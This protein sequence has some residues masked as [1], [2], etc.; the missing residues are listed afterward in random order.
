MNKI[1][2]LLLTCCVVTFGLMSSDAHASKSNHRHSS[3]DCKKKKKFL[4]CQ[5]QDIS[6]MWISSETIL[7]TY[8]VVSNKFEIIGKMG[9]IMFDIAISPDGVLYGL[10]S[11]GN[12]LYKINTKNAS[13]TLVGT[14]NPS[15][16]SNSL[17]F[18]PDGV[19]YAIQGTNLITIDPS[20]ASVNILGDTG[21]ASAGDITFYENN[22]FMASTTNQLILIDISNP[23]NS[24]AIANIPETFGLATLFIGTKGCCTGNFHLYGTSGSDLSV[25]EIDPFTGNISNSVT[26]PSF[27]PGTSFTFGAT[28]QQ[29]NCLCCR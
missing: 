26:L 21:F 18:G 29:F 14:L 2:R 9:V 1:S 11:S 15:G 24:F 5:I 28:S 27:G 6:K 7:A 3:S 8:N 23:P 16:F 25:Y 12:N 10:D 22:L 17:T 4:P 20:T 13:T 19:L